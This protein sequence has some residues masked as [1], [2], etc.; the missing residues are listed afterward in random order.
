MIYSCQ[1][2][3]CHYTFHG[4]KQ[5]HTCP[6]CGKPHIRPASAAERAAFLRR[7]AVPVLRYRHSG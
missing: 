1:T 2:K 4:S 3:G 5:T 6:D 7:Q